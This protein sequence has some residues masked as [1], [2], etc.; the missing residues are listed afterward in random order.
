MSESQR[1]L[2]D[3]LTIGECYG[4]AMSIKTREE[5]K[6]YFDRL[7]ERHIRVTG[8]DRAKAEIIERS[9]LG[10]YAGYYDRE[11]MT[12]V[13]DLFDTQHPIFGKEPPSPERALQAGMDAARGIMP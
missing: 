7:V 9:N 3:R 2:P 5:A 12:R 8:N 13:N 10:Y 6:S 1:Q 11:T 4:P